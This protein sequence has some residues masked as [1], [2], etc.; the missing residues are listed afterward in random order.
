MPTSLRH[1]LTILALAVYFPTLLTVTHIPIPDVVFRAGVSDKGLHFIAFMILS[2]LGWFSANPYARVRIGYLSTWIVL[3]LTGAYAVIDEVTQLFIQGRNF[4]MLDLAAN[5]AG[6]LA[7]MLLAGVFS[8]WWCLLSVI[9]IT[10]FT[11]ENLCRTD[12]TKL[13]P[14][15]NIT[16]HFIGYLILT[17]I[18][19]Y[20]FEISRI[21][22]DSRKVLFSV[23]LFFLIIVYSAEIILQ[24]P[25]HLSDIILSV[26]GICT[27]F[28]IGKFIPFAKLSSEQ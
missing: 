9:A 4:D 28:V 7:G 13:V 18:W 8:F 1:K 3:I 22:S 11:L 20:V 14:L 25:Y 27:G 19:N 24:R 26:A 12:L 21:F 5:T 23:P 6:I 15:T 16:F 2:F 17:L 10:I